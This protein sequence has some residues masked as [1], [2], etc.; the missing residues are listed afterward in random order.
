[1]NKVSPNEISELLET[2][3]QSWSYNSTI[4][5]I[6]RFPRFNYP[7]EILNKYRH[8]EVG[9]EENLKKPARGWCSWYVYGGGINK[10]K[11]LKQAKWISE[12]PEL[13]LEYVLIDGGWC[14]EG[15][16]LNENIRKF[17]GGMGKVAMEIEKMGLKS[18]LWI[19]PFQANPKSKIVREHPDWFVKE[20]GKYIDGLK[21]TP[22]DRYLPYRKYLLDVRKEEVREYLKSVMDRL[23]GEYGYNLI[24]LDF[25]YSIYFIPG[26]SSKNAD[27]YLRELLQ[28][29]KDRY[30]KVYTIACGSP[31]VPVVG[32]VDS[33]RVGPDIILS[34]FFKFS[35]H[36]R[37]LDLFIIPRATK[38]IMSRVWTKKFWNIDPDAFV[39]RSTLGLS[40]LHIRDSI[41][42]VRLCE[43]NIFLG[44]DLTKLSDKRL[45]K[46]IKPLL[47]V[48]EEPLL[49]ILV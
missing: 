49:S 29:I 45:N 44:D 12:H 15:D 39:C 40:K 9:R 20:K 3:W 8:I 28:Y 11:I 25:L 26:I 32:L 27:I 22:F 31:L 35:K 47:G 7:D 10:D 18:G 48:K 41:N 14:E 24:K 1:M 16:W 4:S 21:V 36:A 42:L 37:Y 34:P 33:M 13:N 43:G 46:Y 38:T 19:S 23:L 2:G 6:L 30:P 5:K 17:P